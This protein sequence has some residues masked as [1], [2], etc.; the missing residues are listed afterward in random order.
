M[1][2]ERGRRVR[3]KVRVKEDRP[4][5]SG[6]ERRDFGELR[7]ELMRANQWRMRSMIIAAGRDQCDRASVIGAI[8]IR[9]NARV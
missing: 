4:N 9:V 1:L 2:T 7:V 8:P 3:E 5:P 6:P